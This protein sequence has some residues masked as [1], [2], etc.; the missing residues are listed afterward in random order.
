MALSRSQIYYYVADSGDYNNVLNNVTS[1]FSISED[2]ILTSFASAYAAVALGKAMVIAVGA[3]ANDTLFYNACNWDHYGTTPFHNLDTPQD[4]LPAADYYMN[5]AGETGT[6]SWELAWNYTYYA[7]NGNCGSCYSVTPLQPADSCI[8][9]NPSGASSPNI[10]T[11]CPEPDSFCT[12]AGCTT[13]DDVETTAEGSGWSPEHIAQGVLNLMALSGQSIAGLDRYMATAAMIG[14]GCYNAPN[15]CYQ[16]GKTFTCDCGTPVN[17]EGYGVLQDTYSSSLGALNHAPKAF[18]ATN[19]A[20]QKA[21][22][23]NGVA[24][25]CNVLQDPGMV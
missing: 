10:C 2:Q 5:A 1:A 9:V 24:T 22:F 15:L 19:S 11:G 3:A 12:G 8:G 7:L 23:P 20:Q 21:F 17:D 25:A 14:Q 18:D 16:Q 4:T 6:D 13:V